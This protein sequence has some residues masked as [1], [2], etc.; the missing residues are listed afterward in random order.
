MADVLE[1]L[2]KLP[3]ICATRLNTDNSAI[4]IKRGIM[5]YWPAS[6]NLDVDK[7]NADHKITL[8]QIMAMEA[9]SMFGWEVPLAD[10]DYYT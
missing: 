10:P 4:F 7:F 8:A 3:E 2:K 6:K 1:T 9:G 5:G